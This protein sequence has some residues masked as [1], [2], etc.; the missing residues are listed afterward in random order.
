MFAIKSFNKFNYVLL[1]SVLLLC[2]I[3]LILQKSASQR[4][5]SENFFLKQLLW[6]LLGLVFL[7]IVMNIDYL[8]LE[9]LSEIIYIISIFLLI[10][11]FAFS[12]AYTHRWIKIGSFSLQPSEV[13]KLGIIL[14]LSKYMKR[15]KSQIEDLK[16][17][18]VPFLIIFIPTILTAVQPD[19]S[20]AI[21]IMAIS[22]SIIFWTQISLIK[23]FLIFF[24]P[25]MSMIIGILLSQNILFIFILGIYFFILFSLVKRIK[26]EKIDALIILFFNIIISIISPLFWML[27]KDYQKDRFL[28]FLNPE[29]NALG[30][31][32]NVIQSKIAIGSGN[33]CGKGFCKGT[34]TQ[35][36]FLPSHHTD[37]I[38]SVLGEEWGFIG[39]TIVL[40]LYFI[41]LLESFK[42]AF[43]CKDLFGKLVIFGIVFLWLFHIVANIGMTMGIIPVTGLP[44]PLLSYG[45]TFLIINLIMTGLILNIG[46]KRYVF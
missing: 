34:Q 1:I 20:S 37:F 17:I 33:L 38:F 22:L 21:V 15:K 9:R 13:V 8:V 2:C 36:N 7:V 5:D 6:M 3:G 4:E 31:G 32:Y 45:G 19:L 16:D 10:I 41:I 40:F 24:F 46:V 39:V 29:K 26:I 23:F 25:L 14:V 12:V 27:L 28:S 44:L 42:I 35:L 18:I 11:G 30:K 43:K